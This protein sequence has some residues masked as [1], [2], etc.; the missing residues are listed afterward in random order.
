MS[1]IAVQQDADLAVAVYLE[2]LLEGRRVLVVGRLPKSA[3]ERITHVAQSADFI[4]PPAQRK[5]S[6]GDVPEL[7]FRN[8]ALDVVFVQ[9]LSQLPEPREDAVAELRRV[10]SRDGILAICAEEAGARRRRRA[11]P[12][13]DLLDN[14]LGREFGNVR[15]FSQSPVYG[16]AVEEVGE[17]D[18]DIAVDTALV[19]RSKGGHQRWL[20]LAADVRVKADARLWVQLPTVALIDDLQDEGGVGLSQLQQALNAAEQE[21]RTAARREADALRELEAERR[22]RMD[23]E[24]GAERARRLDERLDAAEADFDDAVARV[25]WLESEG[26]EKEALARQEHKRRLEAERQVAEAKAEVALAETKAEAARLAREAA[27]AESQALAQ[28]CADLEK[29]LVERAEH[30]QAL[31]ADAKRQEVV[32]KDLLEDLRRIEQQRVERIEHD[33]RVS[34]LEIE[35]DRAIQRALEAEVAREAAQM[36]VDELRT[37][38]HARQT[39]PSVDPALAGTVLGLKRRVSELERE[40]DQ[41]RER[42]LEQRDH[43]QLVERELRDAL[44]EASSRQERAS[45]SLEASSERER[46]MSEAARGER[47]GLLLRVEEAERALAA[48]TCN[49]P[50]RSS[51]DTTRVRELVAELANMRSEYEERVLELEDRVRAADQRAEGLERELDEADRAAEAYSDDGERLEQLER[52][53]RALRTR[54]DEV[55]DELRA[56]QDDLGIARSDV[57]NARLEAS[58]RIELAQRKESEARAERDEARAA[59]EEARTIL[60]QLQAAGV[61]LID[62]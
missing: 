59:L 39:R 3:E 61:H 42:A 35:R 44:E 31:E 36:H 6:E 60:A 34:E 46:S 40:L 21:A 37:Q 57:D 18:S 11:A 28:E 25:R 62:A 13:S 47:T 58:A 43:H 5:P 7:P 1:D 19:Q 15:L 8:G 38:L 56:A 51:E 20:A 24:H 30:I 29:R 32:A 23:A 50:E 48:L 49:V 52:D 16:Q 14:L 41:A 9:D 45:S 27:H 55:E 54:L 12:L 22:L 10:L 33:A 53:V 4:H 17:A 2:P 26:S